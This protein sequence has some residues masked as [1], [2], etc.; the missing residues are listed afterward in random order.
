M[1]STSTAARVETCAGPH[2]TAPHT[3]LFARGSQRYV[4]HLCGHLGPG[5]TG[6]L[7]REL[8]VR[9]ISIERAW[10]RRIDASRWEGEFEF[11]ALEASLNLFE[12]DFLRLAR[13]SAE[14]RRR[15]A[16]PLL[17]AFDLERTADSVIVVLQARDGV[18]LLDG[19]LATF[20]SHALFPH[21]M[22]ID[23]R[24]GV[25]HD[26]FRLRTSGGGAPSELVSAALEETLR[27]LSGERRRSDPAG[28]SRRPPR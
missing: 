14:P 12:I 11:R 7:A 6:S 10:A 5:W 20:A 1:D 26:L 18:G 2:G 19:V 28:G 4:L 23:T 17:D 24:G 27:A 9:R 22:T 16:G 15:A 13:G 25:A 21:E 8:S 3:R